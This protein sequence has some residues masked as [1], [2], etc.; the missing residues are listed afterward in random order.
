MEN[1]DTGQAS[2]FRLV[3]EPSGQVTT[4]WLLCGTASAQIGT[5]RHLTGGGQSASR[6]TDS[7]FTTIA[8]PALAV[9]ALGTVSLAWWQTDAS[10]T[11]NGPPML[12]HRR[13]GGAWSTPFDLHDGIAAG[14]RGKVGLIDAASGQAGETRA[15]WTQ[16]EASNTDFRAR[17]VK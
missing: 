9:D 5:Q 4:A 7:V 6:P 3:A 2:D 1:I 12:N 11:L 17:A 8:A 10:L 16:D 13:V 15:Y 14:S